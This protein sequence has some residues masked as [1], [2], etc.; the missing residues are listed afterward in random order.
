MRPIRP[1]PASSA[2]ASASSRPSKPRRTRRPRTPSVAPRDPSCSVSCTFARDSCSA[3]ARPAATPVTDDE[4]RRK[5]GDRTVQRELVLQRQ[6]GRGQ[7][8]TDG[9]ECPGREQQADDAARGAQGEALRQHL[10]HKPAAAGAERGA[11]RKLLLS[12]RPPHN[13]KAGDV[14]ARNEQHERDRRGQEPQAWAVRRSRP[15]REGARPPCRAWRW[16]QGTRTR[17]ERQPHSP[18]LSPAR[19]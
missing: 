16:W 9:S 14:H 18:R 2:S 12:R 1:A 6:A 3:G 19:G 10:P 8:R 7:Q 15:S 13:L 11:D 5:R 4:Q 17:G